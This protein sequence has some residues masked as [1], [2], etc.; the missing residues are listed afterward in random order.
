MKDL[1]SSKIIEKI[2]IFVARINGGKKQRIFSSDYPASIRNG[3]IDSNG[4][5]DWDI[6]SYNFEP[7]ISSLE[8][9]LGL[10]LPTSY[11]L[12]VGRNLFPSFNYKDILIHGNTLEGTDHFEFRNRLFQDQNFSITLLENHYIQFARVD[13]INYDPICFYVGE[14]GR[15]EPQIVLLDHESIIIN[16]K[17]VKKRI[18]AESFLDFI[19]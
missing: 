7:I 11:R 3:E 4:L 1:S 5:C 18:I 10:I 16:K 17:I 12:F 14:T 9:K 15:N 2:S 19:E 13:E 8:D 6:K